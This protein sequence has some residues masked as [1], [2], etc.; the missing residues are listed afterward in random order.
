MVVRPDGT[1]ALPN[2]LGRLVIKLPLPPGN[3]S[4]LYKNDDLFEKTYFQKYPVS[5]PDNSSKQ[6]SRTSYL[7][8]QLDVKFRLVP[9]AS[10]IEKLADELLRKG[11][12]WWF[13]ETTRPPHGL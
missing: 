2:E 8:S 13:F 3:M 1:F 12:S 7:K 10:N 11:N 4:T 5:I 6:I 9:K